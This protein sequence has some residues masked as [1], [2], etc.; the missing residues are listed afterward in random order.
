MSRPSSLRMRSRRSRTGAAE[1]LLSR[2]ARMALIGLLA[3]VVTLGFTI[4]MQVELRYQSRTRIPLAKLADQ[5]EVSVGRSVSALLRWVAFEEETSR[6]ERRRVWSEEIIP[7]LAE[8]EDVGERQRDG[9]LEDAVHELASELRELQRL[10]FLMEDIAH[11]PGN[12]PARVLHGQEVAPILSLLKSTFEAVIRQR[13]SELDEELI[14]EVA[15]LEAL[16]MEMAQ[17]ELAILSGE[18]SGQGWRLEQATTAATRA[19]DSITEALG[20]R[21][22]SS[23]AGESLIWALSEVEVLGTNMLRV[24]RLRTGKRAVRAEQIYLDEV[25]PSIERCRQAA[26]KLSKSQQEAMKAKSIALSR[27]GAVVVLLALAMGLVSLAAL[28]VSFRVERDMRE[29]L[30]QARMLGQYSIEEPLGRGGMGEVYRARHAL[31]RRATA[32]KLL[33]G[34]DALDLSAQERFRAEVQLTSQL[35]HPNTIQIFDYGRTP[36]GQFYYAM[37]LLDGVDLETL[38]SVTGPMPPRRA[39]HVLQQACGSLAEAHEKGLL[40][41]DLKPSN[42]ML[43]ERGGAQDVAKVLD[44][45]LVTRVDDAG[46]GGKLVGTPGFIAPEVI[47]SPDNVTA[48]S[49]LYALGCVAYQLLTGTPP[50]VGE[51]VPAIIEAQLDKEPVPPSEA[52]GLEMPPGIDALVMQCLSSDAAERPGS[53]RELAARLRDLELPLWTEDEARA[54]WRDYG[55]AVRVEARSYVRADTPSR[56]RVERRRARSEDRRG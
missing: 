48:R 53:A 23:E 28:Y 56:L 13:P 5:L 50:F 39:V 37:E 52:V 25:R 17:A 2:N 12:V 6:T 36:E 35:T 20:P 14:I 45:G 4:W 40:H 10:Q 49:D 42:I 34:R 9:E 38:V 33:R 31:L 26:S 8:L 16:L 51:D 3:S 46:G 43:T 24:S 21:A 32:I 18:G 1:G 22:R 55:E 41:R 27:W 54:W 15:S 7:A 47:E 44:F 30:S 11:V 19:V 29:V